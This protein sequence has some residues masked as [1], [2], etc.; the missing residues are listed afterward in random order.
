M[1][2]IS[3]LAIEEKVFP[4]KLASSL[5]ASTAAENLKI[6]QTKL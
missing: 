6:G 4:I 2:V 1:S 5:Q 3:D